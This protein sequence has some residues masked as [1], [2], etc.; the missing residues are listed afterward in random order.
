MSIYLEIYEP[1]AMYYGSPFACD[2]ILA[3]HF[4]YVYK[5]QI[6]HLKRCNICTKNEISPRTIQ[7]NTLNSN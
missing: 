2:R 7:K 6:S 1:K 5:S 3:R 4:D